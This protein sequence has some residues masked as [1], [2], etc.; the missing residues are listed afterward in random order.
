VNR[1]PHVAVSGELGSGKSSVARRL[2]EHFSLRM[3]S[4]GDI[5]RSI[6]RSLN[7]STLETNWLAERDHVIDSKVDQVTRD[8]GTEPEPI[9]FDSR[10]AW[11]M[12][13]NSYK[14]HLLVDPLI[15][16]KR[17][18]ST[19]SSPTEQY[20]SASHARELAEERYRSEQ[21]RFLTTYGVDVFRLRN[22]HLVIDS[23]GA[24]VEQVLEVILRHLDHEPAAESRPNLYV[25]PR[26]IMPDR[27]TW[28]QDASSGSS[29]VKVC[30]SRPTFCSVEGHRAALDAVAREETLVEAEL[31]VEGSE[32]VGSG[33][34]ATD[35]INRLTRE[36]WVELWREQYGL[37]CSSALH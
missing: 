8:L 11:Y 32:P 18:H 21:R 3:V 13:P 6:A 31:I 19:R 20:E 24:D 25:H 12:V 9:V 23:S 33:L 27:P 1:P 16:A 34:T 10:M 14:I 37:E 26:R 28:R 4:T 5:Q 36:P 30:Y 2:A 29:A 22:Y 7:L 15:A 35:H 17:L